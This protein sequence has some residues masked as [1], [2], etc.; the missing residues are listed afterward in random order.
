MM[1]DFQNWLAFFAQEVL[2]GQEVTVPLEEEE[3]KAEP[4]KE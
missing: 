3:K 1:P 2:N 4:V